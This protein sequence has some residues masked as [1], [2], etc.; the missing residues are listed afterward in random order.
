MVKNW[1]RVQFILNFLV[2]SIEEQLALIAWT[3]M[4]IFIDCDDG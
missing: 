1:I 3:L 2:K 4:D